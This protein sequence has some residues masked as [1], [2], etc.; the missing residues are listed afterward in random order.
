MFLVDNSHPYLYNLSVE[1]FVV[2][3]RLGSAGWNRLKFFNNK[4]QKEN[5]LL[6]VLQCHSPLCLPLSSSVALRKNL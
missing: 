6:Q 2:I 1:I 3:V 4:M 5:T